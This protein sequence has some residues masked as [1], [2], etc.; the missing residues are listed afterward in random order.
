MT[1]EPSKAAW[2]RAEELSRPGA[3][4]SYSRAAL[5]RH[6]QQTSDAAKEACRLIGFVYNAADQTAH[7]ILQSL[8]LPDEPD[9]TLTAL[10]QVF[11]D[12]QH[13]VGDEDE[14]LRRELAKHGLKIMEAGDD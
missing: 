3:S 7:E 14:T 2:K 12:V 8:I 6:I 10:M 13:W 1:N 4:G 9:P 11:C 5:A